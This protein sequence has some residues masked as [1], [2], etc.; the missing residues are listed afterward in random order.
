MVN[1]SEIKIIHMDTLSHE[2]METWTSFRPNDEFVI[3]ETY[4]VP[5]FNKLAKLHWTLLE[6]YETKSGT[7]VGGKFQAPKK[8]ISWRSPTEPSPQHEIKRVKM[9]SYPRA[10]QETYARR[11]NT[12]SNI[13][14]DTND[15]S[16]YNKLVK[17]GYNQT[18]RYATEKNITVGGVFEVKRSMMGYRDVESE[19]KA[20]E[21]T[22]EQKQK[23]AEGLAKAREAR[24]TPRN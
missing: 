23:R 2:E 24:K 20:P 1:N 22:D 7:V 17:L 18:V 4:E 10:E 12:E 15:M 5:I 19:R 16:I 3:V 6:R 9:I 14:I 13:V 21:L 11:N 8:F